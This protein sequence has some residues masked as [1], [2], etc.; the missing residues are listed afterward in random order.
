MDDVLP[1]ASPGTKA[2]EKTVVLPDS[3]RSSVLECAPASWSS[4]ALAVRARVLDDCLFCRFPI[5]NRSLILQID[6]QTRVRHLFMM[7][8]AV[9]ALVLLFCAFSYFLATGQG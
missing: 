7:S 2:A 3:K 4:S 6:G 1:G 5:Q 8:C 9:R